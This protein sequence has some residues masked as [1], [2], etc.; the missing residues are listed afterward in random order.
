MTAHNI[1][2]HVL[3]WIEAVEHGTVEACEDQH[4]LVAYVRK[5]FAEE[6]IYTDEELLDKYLRQEQYFP[7]NLVPWEKFCIA[8]HL[9]T[10]WV[11]SGQPRWP[12]LFLL[13]GRGAGKDAFIAYESYCLLSPHS[14]LREYDVDI[15]ANVEEQ[16]MRP[17]KDVINVL[18]N[19]NN[20]VKLSK[21]FSC[22]A[23]QVKGLKYNGVM[24][25]RTKAPG[26]KDG[27]RSGMVVLNEIH[28]YQ[29]YDNIKVFVTSLG[30]KRH[31]RRFYATTNGDV[32]DGPLDE[33][34][35]R[36]DQILKNG[37]ADNGLLPFVCRLN[38]KKLA[39]NPKYWPQANPTL[40]YAP[41][42]MGVMKKEY[43]EWAENPGANPDFMTKRMNLQQTAAATPVTD[44]E[45]VKATYVIIRQDGIK[46][47]RVVPDMRG[48]YCTC[49][50]DYADIN[51]FA[52]VNL[53]FKDGVMRYDINH[54]WLNKRSKDLH[55]IKADWR[56]WE[57]EGRLTVVDDVEIDPD[58]LGEW[59]MEKGQ[60][61]MIQKWAMD[62][63]RYSLMKRMLRGIGVDVDDFK[64][65][66][67]VQPSDIMKVQPVIQSAFS[68]NQFIWGDNP[69]L[70]WATNNT[71]LVRAGKKFGTDTGNFYYAKIEA[72]SRKN[73]P[74]MALVAS[75]VV[76]DELPVT[77]GIYE[78]LPVIV[79]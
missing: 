6:E 21:Y 37:A 33:M 42:L 67:L 44:Y 36:S 10:F 31:P 64:N 62:N 3:A 73:D 49:G 51:D 23:E 60:T 71:K 29:N 50:L 39:H 30:K 20:R 4:L 75:M 53:H 48:W 13:I 66:K 32:R 74:F 38:D 25:G 43:L 45:N 12:D 15:C 18:N 41:D 5:C 61:Y 1:N 16:A 26:S 56:K 28:Q 24:K 68:K 11:S 19:P 55:R 40:P 9:C 52:S 34:I 7:F 70:R 78:D 63:Y 14:G 47:I 77:N 65:L 22:T 79:C 8:L 59:I 35:E 58:L 72:K 46:E 27:M 17:V 69:V 57:K 2:R 76:E 54:S